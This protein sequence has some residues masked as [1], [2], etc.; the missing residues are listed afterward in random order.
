[1]RKLMR[2]RIMIPVAALAALAITAVAFA[3]FTSSGSGSGTGTVGADAGVTIDSVTLPD[4]L[5]PGGSTAVNFTITNTSANTAVQVGKVV[6]DTS[7]Y[8]N[9][10]SGL[11]DGCDPAWFTFADVTVNSSIAASGSLPKSGTLRFSESGTSQDLCKG[12]RPVLHLK[13]DNS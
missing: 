12:A 11:P 4:T 9:G 13:V 3:Y 5:Y 7:T 2:K 8:T 1:M 10:V 6:A